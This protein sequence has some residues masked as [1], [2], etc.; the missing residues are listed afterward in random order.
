[1][2][3]F[4]ARI[5]Q[6]GFINHKYFCQDCPT[7]DQTHSIHTLLNKEDYDRFKEAS[8]H[9]TSELMIDNISLNGQQ[10]FLYMKQIGH[11]YL[12]YVNSETNK[13]TKKMFINLI[14]VIASK[15]FEHDNHDKQEN[16]LLFEN[17]QK[18]NNDLVNKQRELSKL[19]HELN[20]LNNILNNRLVKDPL[21]KLVS[22]YQYRDEILMQID[23]HK[24]TYGLFW[25]IDV[26]DFKSINDNYGHKTGD[27]VLIQ[28]A[29]R[30]NTLP[31]EDTVKMRIAGDEFGLYMAN[32]SS[33]KHEEIEAYYQ[34]F[35]EHV[36]APILVDNIDKQ[37]TFSVGI[38]IYKRDTDELHVLIDYA[39]FAM[40]QA[41]QK[42][43]NQYIIFNLNEY[44]LKKS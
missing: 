19:N 14:D 31:F 2:S 36:S 17:I 7:F 26:D 38:A 20:R 16:K 33:I 9:N 13:Q 30:L 37:I 21:T 25:F 22:R 3:E 18:L 35:K 5:S 15:H 6:T 27:Q 43:K 8:M 34:Q 12:L 44:K 28:I 11:Q 39:D 24:D 1:M 4:L 32:I 23:Q 10:H 41:K 40:Y 29:K 42:G